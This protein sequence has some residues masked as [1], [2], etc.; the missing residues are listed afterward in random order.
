MKTIFRFLSLSFLALL[1]GSCENFPSIAPT[2]NFGKEFTINNSGA[3][4]SGQDAV[5]AAESSEFDKYKDRINSVTIKK[6]SYTI[7][8]VTG[9]A[10]K[11][12]NG[13]LS[14]AK[15]DG[16]GKTVL[17]TVSN[18]DFNSAL[19]LETEVSANADAKALI[20]EA[21]ATSPYKINIYY[22]GTADKGAVRLKVKLN[23]SAKVSVK[24]IK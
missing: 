7:T 11:L 17:A 4:F 3:S 20:E 22:S 14:V 16:S 18:V 12:L 8:E 15:S 9:D 23:I 10:K 24:L 13:T 21:F 2:I 5:N 19:N 6:V 1:C